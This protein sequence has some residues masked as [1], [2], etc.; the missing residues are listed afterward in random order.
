[1]LVAG[2]ATWRLWKEQGG[3]Q[4]AMVAGHSLGEFT[5]LV[6]AGALDFAATVK[7]VRERG[8]LMQAA[9]PEVVARWPQSWGSMR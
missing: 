7:L 5:A 4:P 8:R 6:C 1:M 9:V 2:V 3:G